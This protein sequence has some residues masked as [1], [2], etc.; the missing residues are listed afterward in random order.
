MTCLWAVQIQ[1]WRS[2]DS[3]GNEKGWTVDISCRWE[4][5]S[6]INE[7]FGDRVSTIHDDRSVSPWLAHDHMGASTPPPSNMTHSPLGHQPGPG[8][9]GVP[10][11]CGQFPTSSELHMDSPSHG[12]TVHY[13][14]V[15][16]GRKLKNCSEMQTGWDSFRLA[17]PFVRDTWTVRILFMDVC[18]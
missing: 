4:V 11:G 8:V 7:Q 10:V 9:R 18:W 17:A 13:P 14:T 12:R 6:T 1:S 2:V 16:H 15:N 3:L 5:F